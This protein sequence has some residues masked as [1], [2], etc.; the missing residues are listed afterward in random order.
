MKV[1]DVFKR[2]IDRHIAPVVYL[3]EQEP[4][5]LAEEVKEYIFTPGIHAEMV[6]LLTQL[7]KA[8]GSPGLADL[9][10]S[11]ISGFY[12]SGKSSFAKLVG[13]S[14]GDFRLPDG[15]SLREALIRRDDTAGATELAKA[16]EK[17]MA[18]LPAGALAVV[19]DIGGEA[20]E[21][22]HVDKV[23]LRYLRRALGYCPVDPVAIAEMQLEADGHWESFQAKAAE[24][25][26][27]PW[28]EASQ[29][30]MAA[31]D[32]SEVMNALFPTKYRD[33]MSWHESH[34]GSAYEKSGS[35]SDS[36]AQLRHLQAGRAAGKHIFFVIDEV[37]H[38]VSRPA[39]VTGGDT[40]DRPVRLQSFISAL[41]QH[42]RGKVW[43]FALGQDAL[44]KVEAG[45]PLWRLRDR[46]PPQL[47]VHLNPANIHDVVKRRLLKKKSEPGEELARLWKT[48]GPRVKLNG[49]PMPAGID[50]EAAF[51]DT[52]PLLPGHI[53][54]LLEISSGLR[55]A[56]QRVQTDAAG[57][58]G[59]LQLIQELFRQ[60]RINSA[61]VPMLVTLDQV[62]EVQRSGLPNDVA[63]TMNTIL[64][65]FSA[66]DADGVMV[67]RVAKAVALLGYQRAKVTEDMVAKLL[68]LHA[69][70]DSAAEAARKALEQLVEHNF[71]T[72]T[73]AKGYRL[74]D[75]AGQEW[76]IERRNMK[77]GAEEVAERVLSQVTDLFTVRVK[78]ESRAIPLELIF[79]GGPKYVLYRAGSRR[80]D[81]T[82]PVDMRLVPDAGN[83]E[84][85]IRLSAEPT[86]A[87]RFLW[88]VPFEVGDR[89]FVAAQELAR[90]EAMVRLYQNV[91]LTDEKRPLHMEEARRVDRLTEELKDAVKAALYRGAVY[92]RGTP[93]PLNEIR[94]VEA[95]AQR[96]VEPR[97]REL[98]PYYQDI[99]VLPM[100]L[101]QLVVRDIPANVSEKFFA[102]KLG[103][104]KMDA[105]RPTWEPE[106]EAPKALFRVIDE[107]RGCN[108]AT[109]LQQFARP[110][111]G[112][113]P[114]LVRACLAGLFRAERIEVL[115]EMGRL[116]TSISDESGAGATIWLSD[117]PLK[118]AQLRVRSKGKIGPR[119]LVAI[120]NV[121]EGAGERG[122]STDRDALTD[123]IFRV[124]TMQRQ[125]QR[126]VEER[127]RS[128]P[129]FADPHRPEL[130]ATLAR[131]MDECS[132]DRSVQKALE[133][134]H[135][136]LDTF[137]DG[138]AKLA[139]YHDQLTPD[140][141][142][143]V[144]T[145]GEV[146]RNLGSQLTEAGTVDEATTAAITQ[147]REHLEAPMPWRDHADLDG[148]KRLVAKAY[149]S[150]R[151][152]RAAA[153]SADAE[154]AKETLKRE[155]GFER[156]LSEQVAIVLEP[157]LHVADTVD[158]DAVAP[159]LRALDVSWPDELRRADDEARERLHGFLHPKIPVHEVPVKPKV[160]KSV[161]D[162]DQF[163]GRLRERLIEELGEVD[164]KPRRHVRVK[165]T[166]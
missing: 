137:R 76:E 86:Q 48:A 87:D 96:I 65:K 111:Y 142:D 71:V 37:G 54:L 94:S 9:P 24:L 103:L 29:R 15:G 148:P 117:R 109:L 58:R 157:L 41:G 43:L 104:L 77:A 40:E 114:D 152:A 133:S 161:E 107:Q 42:F 22:E 13:L 72:R 123:A 8:L 2:E 143:A 38:Y 154:N 128:L 17:V 93:F 116:L 164:G 52:Y 50:E 130:F 55:N 165:V 140:A 21:N 131:A 90:S 162:V 59:L 81:T 159:T 112:F 147:L 7:E 166:T 88:T 62:Y 23:A 35:V 89:L 28:S 61:D 127:L 108:G 74:Q 163:V 78:L 34:M 145:A 47:R 49:W 134:F 115:N 16:W 85:W 6:G 91:G 155:P 126:D 1:R 46:F 68:Y 32:F 124:I 151:R 129:V 110:P 64:Q 51:V 11:W 36:I 100:E 14:L 150:A 149:A 99:A 101:Q 70:D 121:L 125:R 139:T 31:D 98:Y 45:S 92:F 158:L 30:R 69:G 146:L 19:L 80:E 4:D 39:G 84:Q 26:G 135:Q 132:R 63:I 136:H 105:G 141:I 44:D 33:P 60:G 83:T 156:L 119:E 57:V 18:R 95:V 122:L 25:L 53:D 56:S 67:H 120:K 106:G 82:V 20:R 5:R 102:G 160:L 66:A 153:R 113:A 144:R 138:L 97:V 118:G 27:R 75:A 10:A 73:E 3:H 12:G 79:S